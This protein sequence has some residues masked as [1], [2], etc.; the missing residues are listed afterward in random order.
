MRLDVPIDPG[1]LDRRVTIQYR[2]DAATESGMPVD[3]WTTTASATVFMGRMAVGARER[4]QTHQVSAMAETRW[5]MHYRADMDPDLVDVAKD[6]RLTY[7]GRIHNILT[8]TLLGAKA[9]IELT[10]VAKVG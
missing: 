3:D 10:S 5:V 7:Q 8:A 1:S 4:V 6:R 9:A 2:I